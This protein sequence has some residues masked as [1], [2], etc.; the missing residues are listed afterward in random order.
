MKFLTEDFPYGKGKIRPKIN[1]A[2]FD[3]KEGWQVFT[4]TSLDMVENKIDL[5]I[6][7]FLEE[8]GIK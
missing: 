3:G 6:K 8:R 2:I 4:D 7:T 5:G 1:Q